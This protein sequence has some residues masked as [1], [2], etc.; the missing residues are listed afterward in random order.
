MKTRLLAVSAVAALALAACGEAPDENA[1]AGSASGSAAAA[2]F[3]G[4]M[5]TDQ[6]GIDDRSFNASA[7]AGLQAAEA[8]QGI[9]AKY[10]TSKSESDYTPTSTAS[11][12]R[13]AGSS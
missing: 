7:W 3:L 9:E 1:D 6:G 8:S 12:L 11:W 5:V 10:V 4:C 2:D 13:T